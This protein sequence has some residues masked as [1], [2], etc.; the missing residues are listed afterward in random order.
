MKG[1]ILSSQEK[2]D[3]FKKEIQKMH[4][5]ITHG[6]EKPHKLVMI[7]A[8]IDLFEKRKIT[9]N[10]IY[11]DDELMESFSN[12]FNLIRTK[13]DWNQPAIPFFHLR[14]SS[15][16]HHKVKAGR[17]AFY[18]KLR[19]SGGGSKRIDQNIEYAYLSADAYDT[20][21]DAV[22]RQNLREYVI[23]CLNPLSNF[24]NAAPVRAN[25]AK[26]NK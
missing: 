23:S 24:D 7:L 18:S 9:D 15:F 1:K 12:T 6:S 8:V 2:L 25:P 16:W 14:T 22:G 17:E 26:R 11:F 20:L 21:A 4:R 13:G 19:T 5:D 10:R 3:N